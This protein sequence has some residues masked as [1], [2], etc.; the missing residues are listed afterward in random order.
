VGFLDRVKEQAA[1]AS[2]VAKDAAHK[3]QAKLDVIQSKRVADAILRDLGASVYAQQTGRGT[4]ETQSNIER[5]TRALRGHEEAH[6][7]IDLH[8]ESSIPTNPGSTPSDRAPT[9][10]A[11]PPPTPT[12]K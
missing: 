10:D 5:M 4:A 2:S 8:M 12:G 11:A 6:G 7:P 9:G 1:T 3:G